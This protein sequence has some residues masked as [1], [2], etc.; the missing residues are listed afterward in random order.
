MIIYGCNN[1]TL[2]PRA[3]QSAASGSEGSKDKKMESPMTTRTSTDIVLAGKQ[4]KTGDHHQQQHHRNC[5]QPQAYY[6]L[7]PEQLTTTTPS[8][9]SSKC[10]H[11]PRHHYFQSNDISSSTIKTEDIDQVSKANVVKSCSKSSIINDIKNNICQPVLVKV[12]QQPQELAKSKGP[13]SNVPELASI[14]TRISILSTKVGRGSTLVS[15]DKSLTPSTPSVAPTASETFIN[16]NLLPQSVNSDQHHQQ[17][18]NQPEQ[19]NPSETGSEDE[20]FNEESNNSS[21]TASIVVLEPETERSHSSAGSALSLSSS[22]LLSDTSTSNDKSRASVLPITSVA[23]DH[24]DHPHQQQSIRINVNLN[25]KP[26][27]SSTSSTSS[28]KQKSSQSFAFPAQ[29]NLYQQ[30]LEE[31]DN[32]YIFCDLDEGEYRERTLLRQILKMST[33]GAAFSAPI[34]PPPPMPPSMP[35]NRADVHHQLSFTNNGFESVSL[36][37]PNVLITGPS[38]SVRG[39]KNIVRKSINN[40]VELVKQAVS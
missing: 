10:V 16:K 21:A 8:V 38:G 31:D 5:H 13:T 18:K 4:N 32:N 11:Q 34:A 17:D 6:V 24:S 26:S 14:S 19:P 9:T 23:V 33:N 3:I 15:L 27:L 37:P 30:Y 20:G 28:V 7:Q 29:N 39:K 36:R 35:L 40:Y 25:A 22:T 12:K 1:I 2:I